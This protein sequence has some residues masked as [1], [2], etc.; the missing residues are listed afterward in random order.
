VQKDVPLANP[1]KTVTN[2]VGM[3]LPDNFQ[4]G[5]AKSVISEIF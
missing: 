5:Q 4:G 3:P 1:R 2:Q